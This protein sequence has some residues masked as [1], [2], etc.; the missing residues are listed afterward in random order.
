MVDT[1]EVVFPQ[2][3]TKETV[4]EKAFQTLK[5]MLESGE[6]PAGHKFPSED[7]L[8]LQLNISRMTL[9]SALQKLELLGYVIRK[10]GVGTF[11]VGMPKK[12]IDAGIERLEST[13]NVIRQRGHIPGTREISI[14]GM[15]ADE[16]IANELD[17]QIGDPVTMINRVRTMDGN[18]IIFDSSIFPSKI[19]PQIVTPNEIGGSLFVYISKVKHLNITHAVARLVPAMADDF[20]AE[21]LSIKPGTLL[22]RLVQTHYIK[23][24]DKPVL[25]ATLSFPDNEFSW[26][27]IRTR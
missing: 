23:E 2:I 10:R 24:N 7:E 11:V 15:A 22:I 5:A 9:R 27:V 1:N 3:A 16:A 21:K 19:V 6:I 8:A 20:L 4:A 13:S 18:P 17:L 14:C 25:Q 12:R 26:Y